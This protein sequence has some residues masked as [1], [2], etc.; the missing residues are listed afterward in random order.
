MIIINEENFKDIL[1]TVPSGR[2][3]PRPVKISFEASKI[4]EK[5]CN[6][7]ADWLTRGCI[8]PGSIIKMP[9]FE[10]PHEN[11]ADWIV[12]KGLAKALD[13]RSC[14][15]N[16]YICLGGKHVDDAYLK[17]MG[18]LFKG[19]KFP[20]GFKLELSNV[21]LTAVGMRTL[22]TIITSSWKENSSLIL[23]YNK[24]IGAE[25]MAILFG[26]L[27]SPNCPLNLTL[28]IKKM[29][30]N[31]ISEHERNALC[32][33]LDNIIATHLR[34]GN[35]QHGFFLKCTLWN[36]Y[37]TSN[38][39]LTFSENPFAKFFKLAA[40]VSTNGIENF[41]RVAQR[42]NPEKIFNFRVLLESAS[43]DCGEKIHEANRLL[44]AINI[45]DVLPIPRAYHTRTPSSL[46]HRPQSAAPNPYV[47][48]T[49]YLSVEATRREN[50]LRD[51]IAKAQQEGNIEKAQKLKLIL[52]EAIQQE[53]ERLERL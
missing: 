47:A 11:Q 45:N 31:S 25:G 6:V 23:S 30:D 13:N 17:T 28:D 34:T 29:F 1:I 52:E 10:R 33:E 44:G 8:R 32:A 7:V 35:F 27:A 37:Q 46:S 39:L 20:P 16:L 4:R 3:F 5:Y 49:D 51:A 2:K 43:L 26:I 40:N 19:K 24:E 48:S 21:N 22:G 12:L 38:A 53:K 18:A 42:I 14:P 9:F 15:D 41:F 50:I 36:A